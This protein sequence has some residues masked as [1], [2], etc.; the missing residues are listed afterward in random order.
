MW[1][2]RVKRISQQIK[3]AADSKL[4]GVRIENITTAELD[5]YN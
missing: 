2:K 1:E 3:M 4:I 5:N